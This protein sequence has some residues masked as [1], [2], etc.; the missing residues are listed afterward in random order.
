MLA[1]VEARSLAEIR[2]GHLEKSKRRGVCICPH[3]LLS[4]GTWG[5]VFPKCRVLS[6]YGFNKPGRVWLRCFKILSSNYFCCEVYQNRPS[7]RKRFGFDI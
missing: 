2:S 7:F 4:P 1:D 6:V 3:T 5:Q